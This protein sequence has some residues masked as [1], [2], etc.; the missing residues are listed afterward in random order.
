[1]TQ[2]VTTFVR[3]RLRDLLDE[4][5]SHGGETTP[6]QIGDLLEKRFFELVEDLGELQ[7]LTSSES[8][9]DTTPITR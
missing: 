3:R 2:T 4:V 6:E 5:F 7:N 1:M 9:L 8:P